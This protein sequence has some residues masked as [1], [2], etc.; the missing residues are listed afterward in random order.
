VHEES[1]PVGE[2]AL[3]IISDRLKQPR[4]RAVLGAAAALI[5]LRG[6]R[7]RR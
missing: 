6:V 2:I 3:S 5:V 4:T 7:R 1:L